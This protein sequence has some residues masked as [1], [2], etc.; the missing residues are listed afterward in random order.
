VLAFVDVDHLKAVNDS[1]GHA[2]GDRLLLEVANALRARLRP[3][4]LVIRYGGDEFICAI[5][6]LSLDEA[7]KRLAPIN[8]TLEAA[9][10]LGSVT[11]GLADL[12]SDD[13]LETL[14]PRADAVMY[15][16]REQRRGVSTSLGTRP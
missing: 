3:N 14:V 1:D 9:S 8:E 4:D 12:R 15:R 2:A 11:I 6:G 13:S 5:S 16:E 7:A 10:A